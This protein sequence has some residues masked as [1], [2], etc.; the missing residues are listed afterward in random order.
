MKQMEAQ[1][2]ELFTEIQ[3]HVTLLCKS[4]KL[5]DEQCE[6]IA[7][8]VVD[9]LVEHYAGQVICFPKDYHFKIAQRDLDIYN[10]F[11]GNNYAF[12]V[13]KYNMTESGIRKAINRVRKRIV[14]LQQPDMFC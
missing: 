7:L 12:L 1:R 4:Y 14:K 3:D 8:N 6:Q 11:N 13:R 2:H 9:F 5:D 10:D